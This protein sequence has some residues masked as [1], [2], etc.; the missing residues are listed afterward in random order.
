MITVSR[1]IC[2][3]V[4]GF[5][6]SI[7][8]SDQTTWAKDGMTDSYFTSRLGG[9]AGQPYGQVTHNDGSAQSKERLDRRPGERLGGQ[10]GRAYDHV[11]H[12][13]EPIPVQGRIGGE[14]GESY[15]PIQLQ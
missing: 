5:V 1:I 3:L 8:L 10:A 9:Q 2:M 4:C 12:E 15:S 14:A 7:G 13:Y 6:L 11:K